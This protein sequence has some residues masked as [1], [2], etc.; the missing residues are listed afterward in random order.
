MCVCVRMRIL[1]IIIVSSEP[2]KLFWSIHIDRYIRCK[3]EFR[4]CSHR[5]HYCVIRWLN[6][7]VLRFFLVFLFVP[8]NIEFACG[9]CCNWYVTCYMRKFGY[10]K[11]LSGFFMWAH[12]VLC[13]TSQLQFR[14]LD[15][16]KVLMI[17]QR[18][19]RIV[20]LLFCSCSSISLCVHIKWIKCINGTII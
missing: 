14:P 12:S 13:V 7:K 4:I 8:I 17:H 15:I 16:T 5:T 19:T 6:T 3:Y 9:C 18:E 1:E 20:V 10:T 11:P 2:M